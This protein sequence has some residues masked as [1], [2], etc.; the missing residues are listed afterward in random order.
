[1]FAGGAGDK[2]LQTYKTTLADARSQLLGVLNASGGTPTGN[3]KTALE[4]L[5]DNM[6][7]GQFMLAVGTPEAPGTVRKLI[8]QKVQAFNNTQNVPQLGNTGGGQT[9]SDPM[10]LIFGK[11][12]PIGA[13]A[14]D[15]EYIQKINSVYTRTANDVK[16]L[17]YD[18][19]PVAAM[20]QYI[21][22]QP[23]TSPVTG[24][25]VID[26]ANAYGIDPLLLASVLHHESDFGTDGVGAKTMNPGNQGNTGSATRT[27]NSWRE[28]VN[29]TASNLANRIKAV[30]GSSSTGGNT[31]KNGV[32]S[33]GI[34]YTIQ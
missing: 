3:E 9:S 24:A 7:V 12:N 25:M 5:P 18:Q 2:D 33:S 22:N 6:T 28:G 34:K 11:S 29:A 4:Y 16:S 17:G 8:E 19:N 14:T 10:E 15:P 20:N 21:K 13:Y 31:P 1:M 32:T 30:N 23:G 27:F 26:S